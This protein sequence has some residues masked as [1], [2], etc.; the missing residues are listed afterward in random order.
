MSATARKMAALPGTH[1]LT[2]WQRVYAKRKADGVCTRC[3][4]ERDSREVLACSKCRAKEAAA[5]TSRSN[6]LPFAPPH[7]VP[8]SPI[9]FA[10]AVKR[11]YTL[12]PAPL[13]IY[14][15]QEFWVVYNGTVS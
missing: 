1:E 5:N 6:L 3:G 9:D 11:D 8:R 13:A 10:N 7:Q 2:P 14:E 4:R 12:K 15:G